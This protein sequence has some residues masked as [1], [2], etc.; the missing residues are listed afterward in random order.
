[1][2]IGHQQVM[3]PWSDGWSKYGTLSDDYVILGKLS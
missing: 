1:M 3:N 2:C